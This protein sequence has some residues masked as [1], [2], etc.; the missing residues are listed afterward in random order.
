MTFRNSRT[1]PGQSYC[2][3][4]VMAAGVKPRI[5]RPVSRENRRRK[6]SAKSG[7]SSRRSRRGGT[8]ISTTCKRKNRSRRKFH[9]ADGLFQRLIG[10]GDHAHIDADRRAAADALE[11][12]PFEHAQQFGLRAERHLAD[13]VEKDGAVVGRLELADLLLGRAGERAFFVAEQLALQQGLGDG[14]AVEA[15]E[16]AVP[17]AGWKSAGPA[18]TSSL[19]EPLS[20]RI[21]TVALVPATRPIC[22]AMFLMRRTVADQLAFDVQL[23]AQRLFS[24]V[25]ESCRCIWWMTMRELLGDGDG[26]LQVLAGKRLVRVGAVKVDQRQHLVAGG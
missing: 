7:T 13:L 24:A 14:G 10:G 4:L 19:P 8:R 3:I 16:G 23:F 22:C 26:E 11:R 2:V 18:P 20:P 6:C 25:S 1:L 12:V 17:C 5:L 15:D 9:L 21:S